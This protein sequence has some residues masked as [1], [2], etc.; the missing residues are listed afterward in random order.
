MYGPPA[1][2]QPCQRLW[3]HRGN[4]VQPPQNSQ[5]RHPPSGAM[6]PAHT[7]LSPG[8]LYPPF[9]TLPLSPCPDSK[10][11]VGK[12]DQFFKFIHVSPHSCS[13]SASTLGVPGM[14]KILQ[15]PALEMLGACHCASCRAGSTAGSRQLHRLQFK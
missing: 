1:L 9:N 5:S 3:V 15:R 2:C 14:Y 12:T 10:L 8:L 4:T 6:C 13:A 11:L 7:L